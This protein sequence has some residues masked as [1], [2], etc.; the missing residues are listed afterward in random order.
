VSSA[1]RPADP[2]DRSASFGS[3][4]AAV[5]LTA[6]PSRPEAATRA[7]AAPASDGPRPV[8][9]LSSVLTVDELACLLRVNRKTVYASF[10]AGEIPG[11]RRIGGTIRF[12]R[13]A[14]LRWLAEGQPAPP[15]RGSR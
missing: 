6:D 10:R 11:G 2:I 13:D 14:V 4:A 1:R 12:S 3:G 9:E 8:L 7:G 15:S 5:G